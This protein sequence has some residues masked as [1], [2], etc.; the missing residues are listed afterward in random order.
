MAKNEYFALLSE[1]VSQ[2]DPESYQARG[3]VYDRIRSV[4]L[5]TLRAADPPLSEIDI[6]REMRHFKD[7][8]RTIEFRD[9]AT[10]RALTAKRQAA[11]SAWQPTAPDQG[12]APPRQRT[13]RRI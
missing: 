3:A 13:S 5:N 10:G 9:G 4:V 6:A 2:I 8:L 1:A 12:E 7:A 11:R